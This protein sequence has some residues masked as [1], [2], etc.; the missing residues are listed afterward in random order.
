MN[1]I[2]WQHHCCFIKRYMPLEDGY[3]I[4]RIMGELDALAELGYGAIHITAPYDS[5]GFY[6]W[7]G[8]RVRDPFRLN[9]VLGN[10]MEE[11]RELVRACHERG[12]RVMV[13]LNTG[14][15]DLTSELWEN[16]C[17]DRREGLDTPLVRFFQ[18]SDTGTEPP[19]PA[20][21][22]CFPR[23][24]WWAWS[25]EAGAFYRAYWNGDAMVPGLYEPQYDWSCPELR[26]YMAL[27][28]RHWLDTG[29]DCVILDAASRYLNCD[30]HILRSWCGDLLADYPEVC[31]I[32]EGAAG[33][34]DPLVSW[35]HAGFPIVEDQMFHSEWLGSP[36]WDA[37]YSG[38]AAGLKDRQKNCHMARSWGRVCWGRVCW[39]YQ[40]WGETW[41]NQL[42]LLELAVLLATGHMTEIMPGYLTQFTDEERGF[43]DSLTRLG[44]N[45]SLAPIRPRYF[46]DYEDDALFLCGGESWM[47]VASFC[48]EGR[49]FPPFLPSGMVLRDMIS[50]YLYKSE[51]GMALEPYGW[52]FVEIC[53]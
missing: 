11:F 41:T 35:L 3:S 36:I 45:R 49:Y 40:C 15:A 31:L 44:H 24:E 28:V 42:R 7:W 6:P 14:Y 26:S 23:Q 18:W 47:F 9:P 5:P 34:G 4:P 37:V 12:L 17:R 13:F 29:V 20:T 27:F 2:P 48:R 51:D 21:D 52:R 30:M 22:P 16:A 19:P 53:R 38:S 33:F 50:G 1:R 39:S 25:E 46:P 43:L 32:P 10:S 8:L